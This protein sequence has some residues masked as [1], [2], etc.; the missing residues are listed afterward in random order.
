VRLP[1]ADIGYLAFDW[2]TMGQLL[3]LPMIMAGLGMLAWAA[4]TKRPSGN[5]A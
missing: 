5:F 3:S 4:R 2:V 1:D